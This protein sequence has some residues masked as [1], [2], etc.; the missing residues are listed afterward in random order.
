MFSYKR[1]DYFISAYIIFV[2]V[3]AYFI[4]DYY[5]L[6]LKSDGEYYIFFNNPVFLFLGKMVMGLI[7]SFIFCSIVIYILILF[8]SLFYGIS[9]RSKQDDGF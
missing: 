2:F 3:T 9:K 6:E 8:Y 7:P 5:V 1:N 4:G